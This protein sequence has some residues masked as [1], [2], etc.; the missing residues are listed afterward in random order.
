MLQNSLLVLVTFL[1]LS[2]SMPSPKDHDHEHDAQRTAI[3]DFA[4]LFYTQKNLTGAFDKY[5]VPN[6]IQHN[7]NILDDRDAGIAALSDVW[8]NPNNSFIVREITVGKGMAGQTMAII[9]LEAVNTGSGNTSVVD[10]YRM[11]GCKIVEHWD[12]L[13]SME[14]GVINPHPYF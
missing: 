8:A 6:Y 11:S 5:V 10:M 4:S 3:T 2:L 14:A 12:V 7:P 9:H 1:S 13:Q